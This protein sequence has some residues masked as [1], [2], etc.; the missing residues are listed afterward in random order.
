MDVVYCPAV[1]E[2]VLCPGPRA[3]R[4]CLTRPK[5]VSADVAVGGGGVGHPADHHTALLLPSQ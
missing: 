4:D 5:H 1:T 3:L 2:R